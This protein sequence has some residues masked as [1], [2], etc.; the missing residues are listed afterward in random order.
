[1]TNRG[2]S[3]TEIHS[4]AK[5]D[6][7]QPRV[8]VTAGKDVIQVVEVSPQMLDRRVQLDVPVGR[9]PPQEAEAAVRS[10][11][12]VVFLEGLN[13]RIEA[14]SLSGP[15]QS[16]GALTLGSIPLTYDITVG[17]VI[18]KRTLPFN[19][20]LGVG[21][22]DSSLHIDGVILGLT[23]N[24]KFK[25]SV[26]GQGENLGLLIEAVTRSPTPPALAQ[27]FSIEGNVSASVQGAEMTGLTMRLAD[28]RVAG[29]VA[30][31]M[32]DVPRFS[33]NLTAGRFDLDKWL[34]SQGAAL[35]GEKKS[36][37]KRSVISAS[38]PDQKTV[39][40]DALKMG[41]GI[42][43]P[44][45][46][47]GSVIVSVEAL[48]YR[49]ESISD[50]LIST[51]LADGA[52][53]LN[54]FSTQFPGGSDIAMTGLLTSPKG[55]PKFSGNIE[56]TTND[57]RKVVAW[58]GIKMPDIPADRLRKVDF[59]SDIS[60]TPEEVQIQ[61]MDL[62]FDSSRLTGAATIAL[63]SRPAFG[64]NLT[65]DQIN[66]DAY[67]PTPSKSKPAKTAPNSKS[68]KSDKP[69]VENT[70][71]EKQPAAQNPLK[72]LSALAHFD[73]N[74]LMK[75]KRLSLRGEQI[76]DIDLDAT[77]YDGNLDIRK[78]NVGQ[79]LG[80]G[81]S[82]TGKI[83]ELRSIPMAKNLQIK[84]KSKNLAP[85]VRFAGTA[86]PFNAR[87]LGATLIELQA[88]GSFVKPKIQ[89]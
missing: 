66:A 45:G 55:H 22:G 48:V 46:I 44:K 85:L 50:V 17:E 14:A 19:L 5:S 9:D 61:N 89:A 26:K 7:E 15:F 12:L 75:I 69:T 38:K 58:L 82:V 23:D 57:L 73:A 2:N 36:T 3:S 87:N 68:E 51:D 49:G 24:P 54:Q 59:K 41:G 40:K 6:G 33:V 83:N 43:I 39:E 81:M 28:S 10:K 35:K 47:I 67:M 21:A 18:Q 62:K 72:G 27:L 60:L 71:S 42:V 52:V 84:L 63:R 34:N 86:L 74:L 1:M 65:L 88:N 53:T 70:K 20:N 79:A 16:K 25:G 29:D 4:D 78:M 13:A 8:L 80:A 30:F 77:L 11:T 56:T 32:S 31:E 64:V 76:K 37:K